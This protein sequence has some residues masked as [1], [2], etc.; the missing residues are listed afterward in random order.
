[1]SDGLRLLADGPGTRIP[2]KVVPGARA[3][4]IAG[5]HGHRLRVRIAAPPADGRA[6]RAL[7]RFLAQNLGCRARDVDVVAGLTS[8]EK[9]VLARSMSPDEVMAAL[10]PLLD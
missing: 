1:M 3:D 9:I 10:S 7:C 2:I 6:N 5:L 4:G 8:P